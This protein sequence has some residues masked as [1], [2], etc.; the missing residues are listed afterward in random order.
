[1]LVGRVRINPIDNELTP[2][3]ELLLF[4]GLSEGDFVLLE[5]KNVRW[6]PTKTKKEKK[7]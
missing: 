3:V 1:M 6:V 5:V 2:C 7:K 4:E